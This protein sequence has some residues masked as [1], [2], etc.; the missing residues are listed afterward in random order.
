MTA[1]AALG[2]SWQGW[3]TVAAAG[4]LTV[5]CVALLVHTVRRRRRGHHPAA[6]LAVTGA[7][8]CVVL[9]AVTGLLAVGVGTGYLSD[10]RSLATAGSAVADDPTE[11]PTGTPATPPTPTTAT[12]GA[13]WEVTVPSTERGVPDSAT[14]LY[15]PPGYSQDPTAHYPVLYMLHGSPGTGADW[16]AAGHLDEVL[17][18]LVTSGKIPPVVVVSPDLDLGPTDEPLDLPAPGALRETFVVDDVVP[19]ADAHL[20]T[21][22]DRADRVVGGMSAGGLGALLIGLRH[23]STFAGVVSLMPYLEP[24]SAGLRAVPSALAANSPLEVID[25]TTYVDPLPVFLGVPGGDDPTEG[26]RIA[27][28]LDAAGVPEHLQRYDQAEHDWAGAE[29]MSPDAITWVVD[30]LGWSAPAPAGTPGPT[31]AA[32]TTG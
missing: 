17:D 12:T 26:Q 19:W 1:A 23:Q 21:L 7:L 13:T 16:F 28:A 3:A 9:V 15:V 11:V 5:V 14:Y 2:R 20:R 30:Q 10:W 25:R 31:P 4:V 6:L 8:L 27:E 18:Q 24:E 32:A 29:L 22:P